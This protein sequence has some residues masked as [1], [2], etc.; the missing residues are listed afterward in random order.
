MLGV[1]HA[2]VVVYTEFFFFKSIFLDKKS[3]RNAITVLNGL[4]QE[5]DRPTFCQFMVW[6]QSVCKGYQ[7]KIKGRRLNNQLKQIVLYGNK[8]SDCVG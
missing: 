1:L 4:D 6:V 5:H 7:Q 8:N 3:F 2:Y